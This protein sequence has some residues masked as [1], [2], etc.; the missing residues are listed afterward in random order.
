MGARRIRS[1]AV[2]AAA[3]ALCALG[4]GGCGEEKKGPPVMGASGGGEAA[5][6]DEAKAGGDERSP[7][8]PGGRSKRDPCERFASMP[9]DGK[10][11]SYEYVAGKAAMGMPLE[12][13]EVKLFTG[14]M[15]GGGRILR[16]QMRA[17]FEATE[18]NGRPICVTY[19]NLFFVLNRRQKP[20]LGE[21][22]NFEYAGD[23][24][25]REP[26]DKDAV[27]LFIDLNEDKK[28]A[29]G[30]KS[31]E[32]SA[33]K[34]SVTFTKMNET[35]P[36]DERRRYHTVEFSALFEKVEGS[37]VKG[38]EKTLLNGTFTFTSH[39]EI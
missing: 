8:K 2:V 14:N 6:G 25:V 38:D 24:S 7:A 27:R 33:T 29:G 20:A 9:A 3:F 37:A 10:I 13:G 21:A 11:T 19:S 26:S 34:G 39:G 18:F 22:I 35:R 17:S 4:A 31:I 1:G 30:S 36:D 32:Y 28:V 12:S 5:P 15:M 16:A 23:H